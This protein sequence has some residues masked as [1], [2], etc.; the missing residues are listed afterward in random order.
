[1]FLVIFIPM[2]ILPVPAEGSFHEQMA[3]SAKAISL[4]NAVT[5]NPPGHMSIHYNPAGLSLMP[6]GKWF[7]QGLTVPVIQ[8]TSKFRADPDFEGFFGVNDDPI[9]SPLGKYEGTNTA[10]RMYIPIVDTT[11]DYLFSPTVGISYRK[12]GSPWTFAVGNYAPFAVGLVHGASR[13]PTRFGGKAVYQQHLVYAAPAVSYQLNEELSLG[14]SVGLGQTAMGAEVDMRS[15]NELV[16][17]TRVLGE[18]TED[19]EIPVLS[20]LTLPPPWFGGGVGAYDQVASLDLALRDDFS[21]NYNVGLLWEPLDW[22]SLGLVY[23]SPIKVE[24][25]GD[26]LFSYTETW[27]SMV[28]WFGQSPLLLTTSGMLDLPTNP[29]PYQKGRVTTEIELPRRVQMGVKIQP[30]DRLSLMFDLKWSNWSVLEEDRFVFDQDIQLLRLVK[31]LGYTGGNDKLVVDRDFQDTLDWAVG[32]EFELFDWLTLRAGYEWRETSV[33]QELYDLLYALPDLHYFGGGCSVT[34]PNGMVID[35]AG[36]YLINEGFKVENDGSSNLNSNDTFKP[37]YNPYAGLHYEQDTYTYMGSINVT[38]PFEVMAKMMHHQMEMGHMVF[39]LLN[40]FS[41][42][43]DEHEGEGREPEPERQRQRSE[44]SSSFQDEWPAAAD[45]EVPDLLVDVNGPQPRIKDRVGLS[46]SER[47][48]LQGW[49]NSWKTA[50]VSGDRDRLKALYAPQAVWEG[51]FGR[52]SIV[53]AKMARMGNANHLEIDDVL[54]QPHPRGLRLVFSQWSGLK[55]AGTRQG[56]TA[57]VLEE[58]GEGWRILNERWTQQELEPVRPGQERVDRDI[59]ARK[60]RE[61]LQSWKEA[62][63]ERDLDRFASFYARQAVAQNLFGRSAIAR[64]VQEDWS[65]SPQREL[66]MSVHKTGSHP[67][68]VQVWLEQMLTGPGGLQQTRQVS[69]VLEEGRSGWRIIHERRTAQEAE[70]PVEPDLR[71]WLEKWRKA[72]EEGDV[73]AYASFYAPQAIQGNVFGRAEIRQRAR[74]G[75]AKEEARP[76]V[77]KDIQTMDHPR[78]LN[79]LIEA[80]DGQQQRRIVLILQQDGKGDWKILNQQEL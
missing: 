31:L 54:V 5:A 18:A 7:S 73:Q 68:G 1:M 62:W 30:F 28:N 43:E 16:E 49:L 27:R 56:R 65:T 15:P 70:S 33:K 20:E 51:V 12:P 23:Q 72:Q 29:V 26:Y 38:M 39:N 64:A 40:P 4:G 57:L 42:H 13:D 47:D 2:M 41:S 53:Q 37:V 79:V 61:W 48:K 11:I 52:N 60:V 78:G 32:V 46:G 44:E 36:A 22:L 80:R 8:K 34:L 58:D 17:L 25:E 74:R 21:P 55:Q 6:E 71:S 10:G 75:W 50:L 3:I 63:E 14:L 9:L 45:S 24:L 66:H 59:D 19:L 35:L 69:L 67:R 76:L 77:I